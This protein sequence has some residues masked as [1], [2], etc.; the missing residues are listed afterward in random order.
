MRATEHLRELREYI[1]TSEV[2]AHSQLPKYLK[3]DRNTHRS[4]TMPCLHIT[5]CEALDKTTFPEA[6]V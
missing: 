2:P 6:L 5:T 1:P 3:G 4:Q